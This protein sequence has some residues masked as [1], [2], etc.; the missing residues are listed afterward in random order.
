MIV[1]WINCVWV[2]AFLPSWRHVISN[3]NSERIQAQN[4]SVHLL[5]NFSFTVKQEQLQNSKIRDD[6]MIFTQFILWFMQECWCVKTTHH[7]LLTAD[8]SQLFCSET[9]TDIRHCE[10]VRIHHS[11]RSGKSSHSACSSETWIEIDQFVIYLINILSMFTELYSEFLM[12][13]T[14]LIS[15]ETW[16]EMTYSHLK[17]LK[18]IRTKAVIHK[19]E[20]EL[21]KVRKLL[22]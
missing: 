18:M 1:S 15:Y 6:W 7:H 16:H 4:C 10:K 14:A 22:K 3:M 17:I 11:E 13:K 12:N 20:S 8:F 9:S 2:L 5:D 21:K 19:K